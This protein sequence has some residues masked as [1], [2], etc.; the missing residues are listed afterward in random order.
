MTSPQTVSSA[1]HDLAAG[2]IG[3]ANHLGRSGLPGS[4]RGGRH[5]RGHFGGVPAGAVQPVRAGA[6]FRCDAAFDATLPYWGG[7]YKP[8]S[9]GMGR[10]GFDHIAAEIEMM[11]ASAEAQAGPAAP[12]PGTFTCTA[13]VVGQA[14]PGPTNQGVSLWDSFFGGGAEAQ[15]TQKLNEQLNA[16]NAARGMGPVQDGPGVYQ[17]VGSAFAQGLNDGSK[18]VMNRITFKMIPS[19]N[20]EAQQLIDQNGGL[21][22]WSDTCGAIAGEALLM[23]GTLGLGEAAAAR[24]GRLLRRGDDVERGPDGV[25]NLSRRRG[26][27]GDNSGGHER[28]S[29]VHRG[30]HGGGMAAFD[31][32]GLNGLGAAA[33]VIGVAGTATGIADEGLAGYFKACFAAGTLLLTPG[34]QQAIETIRPGDLVLARDEND[35]NGPVTPRLVEEVFVTTGRVLHLHVLGAV[36]RTTAEH[37]FW[38]LDKGWT[39]AGELQPGEQLVGHDGQVATVGEVYDTGC[40]ETVYNLRVA[41]DHTYFVGSDRWGFDLWRITRVSIRASKMTR[42]VTLASLTP[43]LTRRWQLDWRP[44]V[45][46]LRAPRPM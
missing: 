33:S 18:I 1:D 30:R 6:E 39:P 31:G 8:P 13:T 4:A 16:G 37:P 14:T 10:A 11:Q 44:R 41:E 25:S 22:E 27:R 15:R 24:R 7:G 29:L 2:R 46:E 32:R 42:Y 3:A 40:I 43:E 36:V 26:D 38:V 45:S 19:L 17:S 9:A 35:P 34:G 28:G 21:Y 20:A 12:A 23:A 5:H